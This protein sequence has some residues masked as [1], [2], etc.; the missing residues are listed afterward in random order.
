MSLTAFEFDVFV[1]MHF[2]YKVIKSAHSGERISICPQFVF[3]IDFHEYFVFGSLHWQVF[4]N[5]NYSSNFISTGFK[6]WFC[7]NSGIGWR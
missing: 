3:E 6:I 7:S 4:K 5:I 1:V 2:L